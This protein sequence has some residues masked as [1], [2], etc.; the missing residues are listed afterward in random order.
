MNEYEIIKKETT[1]YMC[2]ENDSSITIDITFDDGDQKDCVPINLT[3]DE[4]KKVI[5]RLKSMIE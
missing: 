5:E 4:V 2:K 3:Q 1:L